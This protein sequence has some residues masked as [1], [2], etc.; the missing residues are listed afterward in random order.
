[1][2]EPTKL[3]AAGERATSVVRALGMDPKLCLRVA[4]SESTCSKCM[5]I[6]PGHAIRIPKETETK[7]KTTDPEDSDK[8]TE[9]KTGP[10]ITVSKG[11]CMDCGLCAEVCPTSSLIV[12]DP[13]PRRLRHLVKL[14]QS[15]AGG[16][17]HHIYL[18]CIETG[19]AKDSPSVVE[20]PCLGMLS[21]DVWLSLM[22]DFPNLAV[23][24][25]GDYCPRCKARVAEDLMVDEILSAQDVAEHELTLVEHRREL[26]FTDNRGELPKADTDDIFSDITSGFTDIVHDFTHADK[27]EGMTDDERGNTNMRKMRIRMRKEITAAEGET[28]PGFKGAEGLTG[29]I[30]VPRVTLF[31]AIMRFPEIAGRIDLDGVAVDASKCEDVDA[32]VK[33]CPLGAMHK[34]EDGSITVKPLVCVA[35]GLCKE[36]AP[37]AVTEITTNCADLLLNEP[38]PK[39]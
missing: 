35:C 15:A 38:A 26:D 19:L 39:E 10:K 32:L 5:D 22:L 11:F 6:C 33:A 14:A 1:M 37:D 2:S 7:I 17:A 4:N 24:L 12:L 36:M 20:I 30:T 28:T 29:I 18:T 9:T 31:D 23:Y 3:R 8:D 34:E 13:T 25:P 21:K 16:T 27:E